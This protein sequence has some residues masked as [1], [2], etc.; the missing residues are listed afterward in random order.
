MPSLPST[1]LS[2]FSPQPQAL[3]FDL[4]GTLVDSVPDLAVAVDAA[5]QQQDFPAVGEQRVRQWVGNGAQLLIRRALAFVLAVDERKV[6]A[7]LLRSIH[8]HFLHHYQQSNG[9]SSRLYPG[10]RPALKYWQQQS[11]PMAIVTNKPIQ[12]VPRLLEQLRI[13]TFFSVV[14]GGDCTAEK[15]P[16]ALPIHYACQQLGVDAKK[17]V[18]I[19]DSRNDVQAARTIGMPVIC[20]TYG[21][22]HGEPV[23]NTNPDLLVDSLL[24][25]IPA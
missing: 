15:K 24:E 16:S 4:D 8:Q 1:V 11:M 10:V 19:G 2:F 5:L 12:F 18:M 13:Q 17:C 3:V 6:D 7:K 22:N 25:L 23:A 14:V 21:Y 9:H 20:V